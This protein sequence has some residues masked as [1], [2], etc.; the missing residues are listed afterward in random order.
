MRIKFVLVCEG[1]SDRGLVPHLET[2]CVRAGATEAV[3]EAPDLARLPVP[4]GKTVSGQVSAVMRLGAEIN[5]LFVHR[6]SDGRDPRIV[7][8]QITE[9]VSSLVGCPVHV[10]VV[11]VQEIEAWLLTDEDA[12][13]QVSGKP[14][15]REPL[16]V[17]PRRQIEGT[18]SP[19]EILKEA[20]AQASGERGRRLE[21]IR[22]RFSQLR[23]ILLQRLDID[24]PI[25]ELPAWQALVA[26]IASA[27][28]GIQQ[29]PAERREGARRRSPRGARD[30]RR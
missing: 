11:P 5:L 3:G 29:A 20:I 6:D 7:R 25:N 30:R 1:S 16:R 13:R 22:G 24:G 12:I 17:P 18:A 28:A 8:R 14:G 19:K 10:C 26:D 27:V 23:A 9:E 4:P 21:K 15:G 2:L